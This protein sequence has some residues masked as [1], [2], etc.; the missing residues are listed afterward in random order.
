MLR[1]A[2]AMFLSFAVAGHVH[3]QA[4]SSTL[5]FIQVNEG[6]FNL[7]LD[8]VTDLTDRSVLMALV[9]DRRGSL[10]VRINGRVDPISVGSRYDLKWEHAPFHLGRTFAD[11][12]ICF[13]DV[14]AISDPAGGTASATFRLR[15][16]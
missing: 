10:A 1:Y 6:V 7:E 14:L 12:R 8:R 4:D 2:I 16:E 5:D 11:T 15:C 3:A 9:R 13:L